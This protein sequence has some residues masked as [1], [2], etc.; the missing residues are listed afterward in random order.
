M[1]MYAKIYLSLSLYYSYEK[2]KESQERSKKSFILFI[3]V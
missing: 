3:K 2:L 1:S